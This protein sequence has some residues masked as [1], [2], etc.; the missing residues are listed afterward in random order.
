MSVFNKFWFPLLFFE[1]FY[2]VMGME[3]EKYFFSMF[4]VKFS[5]RT[6]QKIHF[7]IFGKCEFWF[8]A[9]HLSAELNVNGEFYC[10]ELYRDEFPYKYFYIFRAFFD[11]SKNLSTH[12]SG[13]ISEFNFIQTTSTRRTFHREFFKYHI[14]SS[15]TEQTQGSPCLQRQHLR[16]WHRRAPPPPN[17]EFVIQ[18]LITPV[19]TPRII[20]HILSA[21]HPYLA[22]LLASKRSSFG[23]RQN[24]RPNICH[25]LFGGFT[26]ILIRAEPLCSSLQ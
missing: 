1:A 7:D 6:H 26:R 5:I 23:I 10:G 11:T 2:G 13:P 22:D 19:E 21:S 9:S 4:N 17:F 20:P 12:L 15:R 24:G 8:S 18:P 25:N 14:Q 3:L 16:R